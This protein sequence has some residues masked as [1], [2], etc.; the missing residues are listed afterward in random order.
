MVKTY[1][2]KNCVT[3]L[4]EMKCQI[5]KVSLMIKITNG[6]FIPVENRHIVAVGVDYLSSSG[7]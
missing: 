1:F 5:V 6:I 7:E 3:C 4:L 2:Y